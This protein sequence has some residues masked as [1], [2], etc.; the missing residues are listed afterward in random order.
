MSWVEL[1]HKGYLFPTPQC[2]KTF[3]FACG[4]LDF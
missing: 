3:Y 1:D 2:M 4:G